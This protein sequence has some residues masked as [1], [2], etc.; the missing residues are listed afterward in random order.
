MTVLRS[1]FGSG[2]GYVVRSPEAVLV[3]NAAISSKNDLPLCSLHFIEIQNW[4][5][6]FTRLHH[7][8]CAN[9]A[10]RGLFYSPH[11]PAVKENVRHL[12]L[13]EKMI[14][15]WHFAM[16]QRNSSYFR[17]VLRAV[18]RS[19]DCTVLDASILRLA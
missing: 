17:A 7:S 2:S 5:S 3:S 19:S 6:I 16:L 9:Q 14:D 15:R 11:R 10:L 1:L 12:D 13:H 4:R 8:A 18:R